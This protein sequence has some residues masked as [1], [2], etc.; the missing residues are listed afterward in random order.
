MSVS[1]YIEL[2]SSIPGVNQYV[3]S[4]QDKFFSNTKNKLKNKSHKGVYIFQQNDSVTLQLTIAESSGLWPEQ[5]DTT[6]L[7]Y[8]LKFVDLSLEFRKASNLKGNSIDENPAD[9]T[10]DINSLNAINIEEGSSSP[11]LL[12]WLNGDN[13][14]LLITVVPPTKDWQSNGEIVSVPDIE[15]STV[16]VKFKSRKYPPRADNKT[17]NAI[18]KSRSELLIRELAIKY[19]GRNLLFPDNKMKIQTD[20]NGLRIYTTPFISGSKW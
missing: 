1:F 13:L 2:N 14:N 8:V 10:L 15:K 7:Y 3:K 18:M 6:G 4:L 12:W 20:T 11:N 16:T 17:R 9:L 19:S 5:F